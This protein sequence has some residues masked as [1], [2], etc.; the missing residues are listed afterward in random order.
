MSTN[1]KNNFYYFGSEFFRSLLRTNTASTV[2]LPDINPYCT[3]SIPTT[4]YKHRSKIFSYSQ[5][6]CSNNHV[7]KIFETSPTFLE[8]PQRAHLFSDSLHTTPLQPQFNSLHTLPYYRNQIKR[9]GIANSELFFTC[10]KSNTLLLQLFH[11]P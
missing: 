4:S 9:F 10:S 1:I 7:F 8:Q 11:E 5:E 2:P 6:A 3:L